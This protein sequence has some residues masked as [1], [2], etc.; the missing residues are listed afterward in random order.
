MGS[1]I[2]YGKRYN[3]AAIAN[4]AADEDDDANAA[5]D[6]P[7]APPEPKKAYERSELVRK[8]FA[9]LQAGIHQICQTGTLEDLALFWTNNKDNI[10]A[11]PADW[12]TELEQKKEDAKE[13][14][15]AKVMA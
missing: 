3:L 13:E 6:K 4:I 7:V 9:R 11:L 8:E 1:A 2:T 15:N 5:N 10:K 12:R 14:L